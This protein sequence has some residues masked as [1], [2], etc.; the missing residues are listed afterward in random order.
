MP[1]SDGETLESIV[2]LD[3]E[4][5]AVTCYNPD[6]SL[7]DITNDTLIFEARVGVKDE[8]PLLRKTSA[9]PAEIEKLN[10]V[11]GEAK[12]YI[13]KEDLAALTDKITLNCR[14]IMIDALDRPNTIHF[15]L[16]VRYNN[17]IT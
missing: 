13:K 9:D 7:R 15:K 6:D 12:V 3:H 1:T 8:V 4:E 14:F 10:V 17:P 16:K 2:M 5:L 11:D